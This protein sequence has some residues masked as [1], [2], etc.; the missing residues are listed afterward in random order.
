MEKQQRFYVNKILFSAESLLRIINDILDFSKIEAGKL[1]MEFVAFS[2]ADIQEELRTLFTPK[3]AEKNISGCIFDENVLDT[4][5]IGDPLRLKQVFLNLI[6]NAIKFTETGYVNVSVDNV[7]QEESNK[8]TYCF[9][10]QDTGIGL[11]KRQCDKLF[12][13]FSQADASTTRKYGGTGLGLIISKRIV[14]M[15][16]GTIWVE[17]T[18]DQGSTFYFDA[19]F[20]LAT[21]I[22]NIEQN[23]E[24]MLESSQSQQEQVILGKIL[25]VED[26]EINQ[27]IAVELI[28]AQGHKV[29]VAENGQQAMEMIEIND[30]DM[31]FMDIQ[32]PIMDG[33]TATSNIR[34][35]LKFKHLPIVAMSAHAMTG[36]KEIS[37]KHGMNDHLS[38]PIQPNALYSSIDYWLKQAKSQKD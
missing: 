5:L 10:V 16:Q 38:K 8:I 20:E 28:E 3:F 30:Y 14:E 34:K 21:T 13:A 27:I 11:S 19:T 36:D 37:L 26:N 24:T 9:S 18:L 7:L 23:P 4:K 2:L 25:L 35:N 22:Q 6:S 29:E 17:S 15:M 12:S 1:E 32:M 33:L 31:V